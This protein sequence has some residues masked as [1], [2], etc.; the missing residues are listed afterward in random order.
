MTN[1]QKIRELLDRL[2]K[3][4]SNLPEYGI[5]NN[6]WGRG[7][8]YLQNKYRVLIYLKSFKPSELTIEDQ[9]FNETPEITTEVDN[10]K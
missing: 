1:K 2:W 5:Q 9:K 8:E 3:A 6:T 10:G 4:V 7:I